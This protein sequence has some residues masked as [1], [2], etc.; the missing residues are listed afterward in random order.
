MSHCPT[1][2]L[3]KLNAAIAL[4]KHTRIVCLKETRG[5]IASIHQM[6]SRTCHTHL[7]TFSL[8]PSHRKGSVV[9]LIPRS[10]LSPDSYIVNTV[11]CP[12]RCMTT[13]VFTDTGTISVTN[14]H[15]EPAAPY[16]TAGFP[17]N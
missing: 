6:Y 12:G 17:S 1:V 10:I 14:L 11:H 5:D 3:N 7:I 15:L 9:A 16:G 4:V 2:A 13:E 8:G